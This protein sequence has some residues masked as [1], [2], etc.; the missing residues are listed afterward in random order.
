MKN[1]LQFGKER[2]QEI[3]VGAFV[4]ASLILG[5]FLGTAAWERSSVVSVD[6]VQFRI[7]ERWTRVHSVDDGAAVA[8]ASVKRVGEMVASE[9]GASFRICID[10][11]ASTEGAAP[12]AVERL[13][14]YKS[15]N[16]MFRVDSTELLPLAGLEAVRT[17]YS[18][19]ED[20]GDGSLP[21]FVYGQDLIV[22]LES[23]VLVFSASGEPESKDAARI[24]LSEIEKTIRQDS[25]KAGVAP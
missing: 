16:S 7:P 8:N 3:F 9:E 19:L 15:A 23:S 13:I 4:L 10:S 1:K 18:M 21:R 11:I 5:A 22:A 24:A 17:S 20:S 2:V 25:G 14:A 12:V 6:G